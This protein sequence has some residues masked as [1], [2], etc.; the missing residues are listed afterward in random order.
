MTTV[1]VTEQ[2]NTV[3]IDET[4]NT[5]TV[6]EGTS[7]V[8]QVNTQGPQGP[9]AALNFV[10]DGENKVD[11]SIPVFDSSTNKFIA[12]STNTVLTLVDGGNF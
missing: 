2:K 5:V 10:F 12:N 7:T 6:N 4:T 1:N 11:G 8:I 3:T 9:V